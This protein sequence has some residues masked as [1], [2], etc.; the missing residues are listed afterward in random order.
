MPQTTIFQNGKKCGKRLTVIL[1]VNL[2]TTPHTNMARTKTRPYKARSSAYYAGFQP[3]RK[4]IVKRSKLRMSSLDKFLAK[5]SRAT[6]GAARR[7]PSGRDRDT[8]LRDR[9]PFMRKQIYSFINP[10]WA[11]RKPMPY[12][13]TPDNPDYAS[14]RR[15]TNIWGTDETLPTDALPTASTYR[16][17]LNP[18]INQRAV[19]GKRKNF[20][21]SGHWYEDSEFSDFG[22]NR[23]HGAARQKII[24]W[25]V[26]RRPLATKQVILSSEPGRSPFLRWR[27]LKS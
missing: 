19:L 2:W 22:L 6:G 5:L 16:K 21:R 9:N 11:S 10:A 3:Y 17:N 14:K 18:R 4:P 25:V 8:G 13:T 20:R 26:K 7:G 27:T 23:L 12:I 24:N 15:W 1:Y